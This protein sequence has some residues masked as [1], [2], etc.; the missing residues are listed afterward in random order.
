M[1]DADVMVGQFEGNFAKGDHDELGTL[2]AF[3]AHFGNPLCVV[4]VEVL[5]DLVEVVK[6]TGVVILNRE[7]ERQCSHRLLS[8]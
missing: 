4:R 2:A 7:D 5:I 3:P 6:R 1:G 8:A